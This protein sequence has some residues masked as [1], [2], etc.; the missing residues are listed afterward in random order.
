MDAGQ[1]RYASRMLYR[2]SLTRRCTTSRRQFI[3]GSPNSDSHRQSSST[4]RGALTIDAS[5]SRDDH[6][7]L[8]VSPSEASHISF[9]RNAGRRS[10]AALSVPTSPEYRRRRLLA[11]GSESNEGI[12]EPNVHE[13]TLLS[14]PDDM[15]TSYGSLPPQRT[16]KSRKGSSQSRGGVHY[17]GDEYGTENPSQMSP[18]A[19]IRS[20]GSLFFDRFVRPPSAY[21][22]VAGF[23][24]TGDNPEQEGARINGVRVWYSSFT[25][26][27][28]LH[29]LV[30]R[31][32]PLHDRVLD[33]FQ[34]IKDSARMLRLR[35]KR[36]TFNGRIR[37]LV[38]RSLG[39]VIAT[40]VG[41]ITAIA[42]FLIVRSEQLLFDLK[43]GY[44]TSQW[45]KA[46]RFCCPT[47]EE[48]LRP[49]VTFVTL[50]NEQTCNAWRT[51]A[52]VFGPRSGPEGPQVGDE[53]WVIE[54]ASYTV[55]AVSV[56]QID[57]SFTLTMF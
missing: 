49:F 37:N 5:A 46:K 30:S 23:D 45:W 20:Q 32:L 52:D 50:S 43:E 21:D 1:S 48:D 31:L 39:W 11:I 35:K 53:N 54:Y 9:G 42:A 10:S 56:H 28:W 4:V 44:C 6:N 41:F 33:H 25:S 38:D 12:S 18:L 36:N 7:P 29:D 17:V 24:V 16:D 13:Q 34:Q 40:I 26:I 19:R 22:A 27:D 47:A 57:P 15:I 14:G 55:I 3:P 2:S 51:W 8:T